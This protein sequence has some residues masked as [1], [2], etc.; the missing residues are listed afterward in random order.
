[1]PQII[2]SPTVFDDDECYP[3]LAVLYDKDNDPQD[4][5][6]RFDDPEYHVKDLFVTGLSFVVCD[7]LQKLP[8][9]LFAF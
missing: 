8:D 7:I 4:Q 6:N 3:F 1:M 9:I 2:H 5:G